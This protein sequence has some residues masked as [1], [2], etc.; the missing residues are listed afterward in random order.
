M[1]LVLNWVQHAAA[2]ATLAAAPSWFIDAAQPLGS[3]AVLWRAALLLAC[4]LAAL[5]AVW[6]ALR[7]AGIHLVILIVAAV[8]I[9]ELL[10]AVYPKIT[11]D[12][13][14]A[15]AQ[16]TIDDFFNAIDERRRALRL[17]AHS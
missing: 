6:G 15:A 10:P 9:V 13:N 17:P 4:A 1:T 12:P 11:A 2:R 7:R 5:Y 8:C 16:Q 3:W 14:F